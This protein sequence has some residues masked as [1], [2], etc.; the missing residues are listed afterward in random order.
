MLNES[1]KQP[2]QSLLVHAFFCVVCAIYGQNGF[3]SFA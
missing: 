3:G 2:F 1:T